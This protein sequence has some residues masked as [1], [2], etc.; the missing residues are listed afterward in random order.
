MARTS[1]MIRL[2]ACALLALFLMPAAARAQAQPAQSDAKLSTP[3]LEQLVAPI[4]LYPDPLLSQVLMAST[5]PLEVVEAARWAKANPNVSGQAL[6]EAMQK[7]SWDPSVKGLTAAPQTLT[8]MS[9]KLDWTRQLGDAVLAQ[10]ED[11]LAAVQTLRARADNAGNL[12]SNEHQKVTKQSP[13]A[14][15]ST[16]GG[17]SSSGGVQ[18]V[19]VIEPTSP[20][21]YYVP[22]YDPGVI[23]GAWPYSE[24][25][26]F[27][28]Y[29]NGWVGSGVVSF[30]A[31][32]A[33]GAAIW[34]GVDW[35]R[36][37][38]TVNPLRYN[39]FNRTNIA[40]N[41]WT[42]NSA[43]RGN[44]PYRNAA[45]AQRFQQGDRN[46]QR[47]NLQKNLANKGA[48]A[49]TTGKGQGAGQGKG[50]AKNIANAKGAGQGAGKN[51]AQG[52]NVAQNR[53]GNKQANRSNGNRQHHA[54]R[55]QT[56][57]NHANRTQANRPPHAARQPSINRQAVAR[58]GGAHAQARGAGA[59]HRAAGGRG[60]GR[61]GRR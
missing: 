61:G 46:A 57:R 50:Q 26:P 39:Q 58:H 20:D 45:V 31:G 11:V 27:Y 6:Q 13:P 48:A 29:P 40:N 28:W 52:K 18:Q 51:A 60:G 21:Q 16:S 22:I 35:W 47:Q 24:Y 4:A 2:A 8:M 33:V 59:G 3:Q 36:R 1:S 10:Q 19:I 30:A 17:T 25:E 56:N 38:V 5:Y 14:G 49:K 15:R 41:N 23:Y 42:H 43:H 9:D 32:V 53:S 7:Q 44:V 37:S 12:K 54:N 34:G 55:T